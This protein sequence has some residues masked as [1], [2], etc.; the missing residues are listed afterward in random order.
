MRKLRQTAIAGAALA[1][2][3]IIQSCQSEIVE[4]KKPTE[5]SENTE[6]RTLV[7]LTVA[8]EDTDGL[9]R[10]IQSAKYFNMN[11]EVIGLGEKW[12]GGNLRYDPGG[13]QKVNILKKALKPYESEEHENTILLFTDAYDVIFQSGEKEI[14]EKFDQI[15]GKIVISA[16]DLLWPDTSLES[17]SPLLDAT[18]PPA[19]NGAIG[20]KYL[21][22]G[23]IIGYAHEILKLIN[24]RGDDVADDEDD[25]LYYMKAYLDP[26]IREELDIRLD[27]YAVLFQNMNGAKHEIQLEETKMKNIVYGTEP[28]VLLGWGGSCCHEI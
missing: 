4:M 16:E 14:L 17:E 13:A 28:P 24:Y 22:S 5:N 23:G 2:N 1:I 10:Y 15:G 11:P 21:C 7:P 25:Q 9:K 3:L 6:K 27:H 18:K 8:T 19:T 12:V 20:K 26:K